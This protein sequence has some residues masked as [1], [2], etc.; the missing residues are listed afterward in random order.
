MK[1]LKR[2]YIYLEDYDKIIKWAKEMS[3]KYDVRTENNK[4]LEKSFPLSLN[5][6]FE[7]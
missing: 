1:E 2:V 3:Y 7:K 4:L 6:Y 5:K